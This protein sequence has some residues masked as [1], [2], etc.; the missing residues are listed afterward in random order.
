MSADLLN[1]LL[2][3][4]A[5]PSLALCPDAVARVLA[6]RNDTSLRAAAEA[7]MARYPGQFP[8]FGARQAD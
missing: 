3:R 8:L 1:D 7:V 5:D 4:D 6:A 2:T